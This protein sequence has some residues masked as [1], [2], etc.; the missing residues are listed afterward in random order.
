MIIQNPKAVII[1]SL[2]DSCGLTPYAKT[3][4][5]RETDVSCDLA[6]QKNFT[7]YYRVRRDAAWLNAYYTY[8]EEH[9]NTEAL[10]FEDILRF[11]SE[12]PHKVRVSKNCPNGTD[13]TVEASF[14]SKMLATIN[15]EYPIW[16]SQ[17]IRA[18]NVQIPY[19][20]HGE[21]KI[22]AYVKAYGQL[23]QEIG[24]FLLTAEGRVCVELFDALFPNYRYVSA[25]KKM[26]FY[27]WNIGKPP[28]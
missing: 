15:P 10:T 11:L 21:D 5:L 6:Y 24:D 4:T 26:D 16:D 28:V 22:Q 9:K 27:L 3:L 13:K 8:M 7:S 25:F 2:E 1:K 17:V 20:L 12:V 18:L 23:T 19:D 14:S